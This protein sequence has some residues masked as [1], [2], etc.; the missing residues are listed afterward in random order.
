MK[1]SW[2]DQLIRFENFKFYLLK[3]LEKKIVIFIGKMN[4]VKFGIVRFFGIMI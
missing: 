3:V 4:G 2:C 1:I